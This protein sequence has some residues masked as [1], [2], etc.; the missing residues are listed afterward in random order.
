MFSRSSRA[1]TTAAEPAGNRTLCPQLAEISRGVSNITDLTGVV[2][3]SG[4]GVV[5]RVGRS[6]ELEV[7]GRL[8]P[9]PVD[10]WN[11]GP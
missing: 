11:P 5:V 8:A 3:T 7:V 9:P 2:P 6:G 10:E 1:K 4:E